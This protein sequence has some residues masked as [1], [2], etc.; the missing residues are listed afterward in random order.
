[1]AAG[2]LLFTGVYSMLNFIEGAIVSA[3]LV[4]ITRVVKPFRIY[5]VKLFRLVGFIFYF[6]YELVL[7]NLK[8]AWDIITPRHRMT[9][10]IVA[11]PL[12]AKTD[13]EITLLSTCITLTP[14]TLSLDISDDKKLLFVHVMYF[15]TAENVIREIKNGFERRILE[16]VR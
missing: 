8:I 16:I 2:W 4:L 9:P 10:G 7:A 15:D 5:T 13:L 12:D 14:G 3:V 11:V 1:M 6:L